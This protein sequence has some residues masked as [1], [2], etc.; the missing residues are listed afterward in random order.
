MF[1]DAAGAVVY[2]GVTSDYSPP[3]WSRTDWALLGAA[4]AWAV[5]LR[6]LFLA[7]AGGHAFFQTPIMD[8]AYHDAWARRIAGGDF[9]GDEV[10]FRAPLYPYFL[11][12]LYRLGGGSLTF[13]RVAQ[14]LV[15]GAS[16]A[17]CYLAGREFFGRRAGAL[18]AFALATLWT[19][20][21]YD[22][23]LKLVVL[24]V[25]LGLAFVYFTA[26]ACRRFRWGDAAAAGAALGLNA[27]T[28]PNVLLVGAFMWLA[29]AVARRAAGASRRRL[30]AVLAV[31][32]GVA[33][34]PIA[35]V[36]ARNYAVGRD[37]VPI[38]WQGGVNLWIGNNPDADG[39]TAIVPG[40]YGDW[41]RGYYEAIR[42]AEEGEGR[43][44]KPSEIDRWYIRR[45]G[46]FVRERPG[47]ELRL[48]A[49]KAYVY[50]NAYEVAN[51]F[52]L[53]Y[54]KENFALLKYDP[55]SLY[56]VLPFALFGVGA[57]VRRRRRLA[58]LYLFVTLYSASVVLFF[59]NARFRMPVVPFF[60]IFAAA[61]FFYF[62]DN[63]RR[64]RGRDAAL[65]V[66]V[67]AALFVAC[68]GDFLGVARRSTYEAQAHY[69]MGTIY[70]E[71]G[72][73]AAAE[74]EYRAVLAAGAGPDVVNA[75]N[76]MGIIAARRGD[77]AAAERYYRRAADAD[78]AYSKAWNNLGNLAVG[79]GDLAAARAC[80]E[81]ALAGDPAD[82]RAYYFYGRLLQRQGDAA[83]AASRFERA[84]YFQPNF[85]EAWY[86]RGR[87][88]WRAGDAPAARR[89]FARAVY[90]AP[91][92]PRALA[93]LAGA[94]LKL[95]EAAAAER[96]YRRLLSLGESANG[97]YNLAC[98]LARRG[99]A[100]EAMAEL[101]AAVK[102]EPARYKALAPRD[103]DLAALRGRADFCA[104]TAP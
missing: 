63:L 53:Y 2:W 72:N 104:L 21:Y 16:A 37:V 56:V 19:A 62:W 97:R 103:A 3:R 101:T 10:F 61:A 49:R 68:D 95:G 90:F 94:E 76:D 51:N 6:L 75:W 40:T 83:G 25:P 13:A 54:L 57:F 91:T 77:L 29:F 48:L 59:V 9:W 89:F 33:A 31:L 70:L 93:A 52:D 38:A 22:V 45:V 67:L 50:V 17:L 71:R 100:D 30:A 78:P 8:M 28:R 39:M 47:A 55:V 86:E 85:A 5:A 64:W 12:L 84:T 87:L 1:E 42:M 88:A 98:A 65:R 4:A 15:G 18:A 102:L 81:R 99:R 46:A 11:A 60:C 24:E 82:G 69:T 32:Y 58:P 34:L 44:L 79:R 74:E 26:R 36:G 35:V 7:G 23:E 92:S 66:G 73:M 43:R 27:V 41:W 96:D 80:Y 14:A 20:I